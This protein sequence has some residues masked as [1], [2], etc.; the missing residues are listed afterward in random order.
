MIILGIVL[1]LFG[2][3]IEVFVLLALFLDFVDVFADLFGLFLDLFRLFVGILFVIGFFLFDLVDLALVLCLKEVGLEL[4][5]FVIGIFS[6][7][8]AI[9]LI[10]LK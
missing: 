6:S 4:L 8:T 9:S 7:L 5:F 2:L 10:F 3:G 1:V